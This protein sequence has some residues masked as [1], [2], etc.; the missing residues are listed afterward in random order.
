MRF[1]YYRGLNK[2]YSSMMK[3]CMKYVTDSNGII[4]VDKLHKNGKCII[5]LS[6]VTVFVG[7]LLL[8]LALLSLI[9]LVSKDQYVLGLI[10]CCIFLLVGAFIANFSPSIFKVGFTFY[11]TA[12]C[13]AD[14]I[15]ISRCPF[16][17]RNISEND[18]VCGK[19]GAKFKLQTECSNCGVINSNNARFCKKCGNSLAVKIDNNAN[20]AVKPEIKSS[21][22]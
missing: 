11:M 21:N 10:L 19:C 17:G 15:V 12:K 1:G 20:D 18:N 16:C 8:G 4:S 14:D 22:D 5:A 3:R 9:M 7:I 6:L 13:L 2:F